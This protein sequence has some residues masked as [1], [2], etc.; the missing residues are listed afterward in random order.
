VAELVPTN[1]KPDAEGNDQ[2]SE[3]VEHRFIHV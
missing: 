3:D 1:R 2:D